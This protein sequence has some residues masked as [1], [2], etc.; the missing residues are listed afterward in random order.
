MFESLGVDEVKKFRRRSSRVL[1]DL[2]LTIGN[3]IK[4]GLLD[5]IPKYQFFGI[6]TDEVTDISN[7]QNLIN[8]FKYYT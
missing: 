7:V 3:Q 2:L 1:R 5:K 6:L 8:F 4:V